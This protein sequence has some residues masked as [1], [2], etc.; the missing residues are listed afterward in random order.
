MVFNQIKKM[1]KNILSLCSAFC[2][3]LFFCCNDD[4]SSPTTQTDY[5]ALDIVT[6]LDLFDDNGQPVGRWKSPN[7]NPGLAAIYPIPNIGI[8]S[9]FSTEKME[10]IWLIPAKCALDS[11]TANI[12]QLSTSLIYEVSELEAAQLKDIPLANFNGQAQFNFTDVAKGFYKFFYQIESGELFW[13]N[14][15][16]DPT[17][18]N[19]PDFSI[20]DDN[21]N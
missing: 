18:S 14:M 21:C 19:I 5:T 4:E 7:H 3:F 17:V 9:V 1:I 16:I 10:R 2:L 13:Q 8:V 20:L 15:Y 12:P 6:G 11:V